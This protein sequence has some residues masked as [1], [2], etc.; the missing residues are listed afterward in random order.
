MMRVVAGKYRRRILEWP[1]DAKHIRP[2]KDRI[3]E[4]IF[5]ALGDLSNMVTLDLYAGSG[6]M[7]IEALSRNSIKAYFV[8]INPVALKTIKKNIESLKIPTSDAQ[9]LSIPD[10]K[11]IDYLADKSLKMDLVIIDPP[12]KEGKYQETVDL[13]INKN[14]LADNAII[15]IEADTPIVIDESC[16]IKRKDYKYGEINVAILWR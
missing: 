9:I 12:Y 16:Y 14:V 13:L 1:D 2:T 7:G 3:R 8:D 5:N 10:I 4:S 15:V 6:A 11:A